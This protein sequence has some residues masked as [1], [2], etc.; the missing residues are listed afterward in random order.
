M[1]ERGAII[2]L[3]GMVGCGK[4]TQ[5]KAV[6]AELQR[7]NIDHFYGREPGGVAVAE[8]I[9]GV[10][11]DPANRGMNPLAEM[12]LFQAARAEYFS[13]AVI[14]K[15][16]AGI[17]VVTDR[18]YWSTV[19]FQGYGFGVD[20][21]QILCYSHDAVFGH[22]PNLTFVFDVENVEESARR[23]RVASGKA[24]EAD[25]FEAE[26]LAFQTRVR[27]GYRAIAASYHE[28][29]NV[30]LI[31]HHEEESDIPARIAKISSEMLTILVPFLEG[32]DGV[33]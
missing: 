17:T 31:S 10:L 19:A 21:T 18:S 32:Y 30:H 11:L 2:V 13:K 22:H 4:T 6:T 9:R 14:P 26:V 12:L 27:D 20:L 29:K 15:V 33:N 3:E 16:D 28:A 24:G 5:M 7:Q 8:K 23:A 1:V 25:R